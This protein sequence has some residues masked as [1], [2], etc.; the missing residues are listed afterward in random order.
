MPCLPLAHRSEQAVPLAERSRL[1]SHW[2]PQHMSNAAQQGEV[3]CDSVIVRVRGH[4]PGSA[5]LLQSL[6]IEQ[7]L[8]PIPN[9]QFD[10]LIHVHRRRKLDLSLVYRTGMVNIG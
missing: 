2:E 10:T 7:Y 5:Q 4:C 6:S 3:R 1:D 8:P 9:L